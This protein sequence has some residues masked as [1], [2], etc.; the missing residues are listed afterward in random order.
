MIE[1]VSAPPPVT[2]TWIAIAILGITT[3]VGSLYWTNPEFV[4]SLLRSV[5]RPDALPIL[6]ACS[7]YQDPSGPFVRPAI[8]E[9]IQLAFGENDRPSTIDVWAAKYHADVEEALEQHLGRSE[10]DVG[11]ECTQEGNFPPVPKIQEIAATLPPWKGNTDDL[12]FSDTSTVL[13]E[14]LRAYECALV[15]RF[16]F[17]PAEVKAEEERRADASQIDMPNISELWIL[18]SGQMEQTRDE[19]G[20]ARPT[21][22]RALT[23]IG[24]LDRIGSLGKEVECLQRA[25][26]DLR[27]SLALSADASACL[28]RIW[29]AKDL[30]RDLFQAPL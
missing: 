26:I 25:S 13:L 14:Y 19:I 8:L 28:P 10:Q 22:S 2:K 11:F 3:A 20:V 16:L 29:E 1:R 12:T 15:E 17:I 27:N 24:G 21:L 7:S 23:F 9:V 5:R 6:G 18:T 30:L 4:S